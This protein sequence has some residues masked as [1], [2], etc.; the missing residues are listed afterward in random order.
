MKP[1]DMDKALGVIWMFL[2]ASGVI[3]SLLW[4]SGNIP[5]KPQEQSSIYLQQ[6]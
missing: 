4:Y 5:L 6:H 2:V 3:V 1:L